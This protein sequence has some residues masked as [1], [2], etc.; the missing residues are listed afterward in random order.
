MSCLHH[1]LKL[2]FLP[3][4]GFLAWIAKEREGFSQT[5]A[6]MNVDGCSHLQL[7]GETAAP[8][9]CAATLSPHPCTS[10]ARGCPTVVLYGRRGKRWLLRQ[11]S[12]LNAVQEPREATRRPLRSVGRAKHLRIDCSFNAFIKMMYAAACWGYCL[13]GASLTP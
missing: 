3:L 4:Y 6:T 7:P 10:Q 13:G 5:P 2:Q 8:S 9:P 1:G 11:T 12:P